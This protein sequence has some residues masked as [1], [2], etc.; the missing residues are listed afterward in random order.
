MQDTQARIDLAQLRIVDAQ[1]GH[2]AGAEGLDD[3]VGPFGEA[4]GDGVA[5]GG[6]EVDAEPELGRV[7]LG[8]E[9]R[10]VEAADPVLE[11]LLAAQDVDAARAF[12]MDDRGAIVGEVAGGERADRRPG[13]VPDL[14]AGED[15]ARV[16]HVGRPLA[17]GR[18]GVAGRGVGDVRTAGFFMK[19]QQRLDLVE[20]RDVRTAGCRYV[21]AALISG[22]FQGTEKYVFRAFVQR[23]HCAEKGSLPLGIR[24]RRVLRPKGRACGRCVTVF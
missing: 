12:G 1:A 18:V 13:G 23:N 5:I 21:R 11:R 15:V 17:R 9:L 2:D 8:P 14:E 24:A 22:T 6:G 19:L 10:A 3:H 16:E 20:Q 7:E 4:H